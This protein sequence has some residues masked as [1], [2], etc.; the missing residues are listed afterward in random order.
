MRRFY[1]PLLVALTLAAIAAGTI[2]DATRPPH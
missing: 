2:V 1:A